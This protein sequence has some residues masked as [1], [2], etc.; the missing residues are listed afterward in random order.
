M[1][2]IT[3]GQKVVSGYWEGVDPSTNEIEKNKAVTID[4]STYTEPVEVKPTGTND[5]M[6][7]VTVTLSNNAIEANKAVS[8]NASTYTEAVEVTPTSPN[9]VMK[10]V[11][12]TITD[13]TKTLFAWKN[14][15]AI[16]YTKTAEPT[17]SDKALVGASTG[18]SESAISAVG[19][20][21]AS[22]TVSAVEYARYDTGDVVID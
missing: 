19:E 16:I 2:D 20:D 6:K 10:K 11:T 4:A 14:D 3:D 21:F 1:S 22:I 8:I 15:T 9:N 5:A 18:L 17:T 7:K 12:V 13:I